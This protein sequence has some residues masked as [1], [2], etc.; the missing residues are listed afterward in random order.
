MMESFSGLFTEKL[1]RKYPFRPCRLVTLIFSASDICMVKGSTSM[2][3][4]F[5]LVKHSVMRWIKFFAGSQKRH[6]ELKGPMWILGYRKGG[7]LNWD[8]LAVLFRESRISLKETRGSLELEV[9][10]GAG[11]KDPSCILLGWAGRVALSCG[12]V[13]D[14]N[15]YLFLTESVRLA[16]TLF[17]FLS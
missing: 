10:E 12:E 11:L 2:C 13:L 17:C 7:Y 5:S 14:P 15:D 9:V 3:F 6:W 1:T 4:R 16:P 8:S